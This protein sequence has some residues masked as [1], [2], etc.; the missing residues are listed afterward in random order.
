MHLERAQAAELHPLRLDQ[1]LRHQLEHPLQKE[2]ALAPG[3]AELG[4]DGL[5]K[6]SLS[7]SHSA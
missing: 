5:G 2:D 3:D 7:P 1:V 4:R 6:L